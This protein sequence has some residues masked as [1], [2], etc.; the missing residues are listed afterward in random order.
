MLGPRT[1][2]VTCLLALPLAAAGGYDASVDYLEPGP[3]GCEGYSWSYSWQYPDPVP[4]NNTTE[5]SPTPVYPSSPSGYGYGYGSDR[6][7]FDSFTYARASVSDEDG[8]IASLD[9]G[10]SQSSSERSGWHSSSWYENGSASSSDSRERS[11]S[12]SELRHVNLTTREG[13]VGASDGC[14]SQSSGYDGSVSR[15]FDGSYSSY[16]HWSSS[17][18]SDGCHTSVSASRGGEAVTVNPRETGCSSAWS[19]NGR[20]ESWGYGNDSYYQS[21]H[22]GYDQHACRTGASAQADD[23]RLAAGLVNGC[24]GWN[25]SYD[26]TYGNASERGSYQTQRCQDG[27]LVEGPDGISLFVGSTQESSTSCYSY[28]GTGSCSDSEQSRTFV[29]LTWA[30]SPLGPGPVYVPL[31]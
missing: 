31:A 5:P 3:S 9:S 13:R 29:L 16:S 11:N 12:T 18:D 25:D 1:F 27:L 17:S 21:W 24:D 20:H 2:L 28:E 8:R 7:C 10:A 14:A 22:G 15:S 4:P 30:H 6:Y 26:R 23:A 19:N